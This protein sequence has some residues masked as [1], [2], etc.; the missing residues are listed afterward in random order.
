M[1][2]YAFARRSGPVDLANDSV[3]SVNDLERNFQEQIVAKNSALFE[4]VFIDYRWHFGGVVH[5][6]DSRHDQVQLRR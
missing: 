6:F 4:I 5:R 2:C 1:R 3:D